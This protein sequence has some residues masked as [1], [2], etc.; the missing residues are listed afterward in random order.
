MPTS[1]VLTRVLMIQS[2]YYRGTVFSI[3]VDGREYWITAKHILT[4]AIHPPYGTVKAEKV[5]LKILNPVAAGEQWIEREFEIIDT[6]ADIDEVVLVSTSPLLSTA[7]PSVQTTSDSVGIGA[8]C[9]FVGFPFGGGWRANFGGGQSSWMPF[10]KHCTV[11]ALQAEPQKI[12]VLDGLNN[13]GFSG[14]PVLIRTGL[15]QRIFAVVSGYITE[16]TAVITAKAQRSPPTGNATDEARPSKAV[17]SPPK[18]K[19]RVD[20]NSGFIIAFD[21][22]YAISA[23]HER[24]IGP[25]RKDQ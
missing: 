11:S 13:A 1:N 15:D 14:G 23:I 17:A 24:P 16:P 6:G 21:I 20:L 19:Q 22:S 10:T 5:N 3:D 12:W 4:G 18:S 25:V 7:L 2:Q 9:S 8:D